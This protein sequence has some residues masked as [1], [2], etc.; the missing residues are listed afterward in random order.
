MSKE[1]WLILVIVIL[2]IISIVLPNYMR[3]KYQDQFIKLF[4]QQ[5]FDELEQLLNKKSV[6]YFFMPF[7]IEYMR[8]NMA[9]VKGDE[10]EIDKN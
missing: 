8:L 10:K 1:Q 3:K 9:F 4:S 6:R 2:T 7:N 5:K